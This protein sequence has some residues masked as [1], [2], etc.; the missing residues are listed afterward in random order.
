MRRMWL[1]F[2][3]F[4]LCTVA[5]A[6]EH[7]EYVATIEFNYPCG[8]HMHVAT[9]GSYHD[10]FLAWTPDGVHLIF[11]ATT[12]SG[13]SRTYYRWRSAMW[14]VNAE[15]P[16]VRM[17]VDVNP[18]HPVKYGLYGDVSPDGNRIVYATCE[19]P[20]EGK[21]THS[22]RENYHYEIA[23]LD[24]DSGKRQRLTHNKY[25][26]HYPVWSPD[27]SRIAFVANP[28][29]EGYINEGGHDARLYSMSPDGTDVQNMVSMLPIL[30]YSQVEASR[31]DA[32]VPK[33]RG[34]ALFPPAWSPDSKKLAFLVY[35]GEYAPLRKILY[36]VRVDGSEL[37]RIAEDVVSVASW[38]P[39]GQRLAVAKFAGD[40]VGLFTLVADGSDEKL[41]TT[42]TDNAKLF[43]D[44]PKSRH[45]FKVHTLS[46]S[47][48]GSAFLVI[49]DE[50]ELFVIQPDGKGV[51]K[52]SLG[53]EPE[54]TGR[55][56]AAWSPDGTHVALYDGY[57]RL[58]TISRDG[59]DRRNLI[60]VDDAGTLVPAIPR[61][62]AL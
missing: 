27:G 56:N 20:T 32:A 30:S 23:V 37:T 54:H 24:L 31:D 9:P 44:S 33:L 19:F 50:F 58:V 36:T 3:A 49:S 47:P 45:Q 15:G 25:L 43:Q 39:D 28:P 18:G 1:V 13:A 6:E 51:H 48:D 22:E 16:A 62:L 11:D 29:R 17:L 8:V 2:L 38:S 60:H 35:K 42:I 52:M 7:V 41:N 57:S 34:V 26:D 46:W 10:H 40:N 4:A 53:F 61:E 21:V 55:T 5:C 14:K 12:P 59:T